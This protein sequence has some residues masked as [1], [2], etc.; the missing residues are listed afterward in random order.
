MVLP[1]CERSRR[2]SVVLFA[3]THVG[4]HIIAWIFAKVASTKDVRSL[5]IKR[6]GC[7]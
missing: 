5:T 2:F 7:E 4:H 6:H 1:F 3:R